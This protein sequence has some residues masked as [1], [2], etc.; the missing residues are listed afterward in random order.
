MIWGWLICGVLF[1]GMGLAPLL[2]G[3]ALFGETP[4]GRGD[5]GRSGGYGSF[6]SAG[7]TGPAMV[8]QPAP[9]TNP[10]AIATFNRALSSAG[11]AAMVAAPAG[12]RAPTAARASS[13]RSR[14][15]WVP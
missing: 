11:V 10:E 6:G 1:V 2:G 5:A 4:V 9:D 13:R 12:R 15:T 3:L 7:G 8:L 14:A